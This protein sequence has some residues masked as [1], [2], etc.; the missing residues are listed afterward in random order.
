L[1]DWGLIAA[2]LAPLVPYTHFVPL[3]EVS[4]VV[5]ND[6]KADITSPLSTFFRKKVDYFDI[7]KNEIYH[8]SMTHNSGSTPYFVR[9]KHID[10]TK[11]P[12]LSF[13][14]ERVRNHPVVLANGEKLVVRPD[15]ELYPEYVLPPRMVLALAYALPSNFVPV[16]AVQARVAEAV[17]GLRKCGYSLAVLASLF[18]DLMEV[19][20]PPLREECA[21]IRSKVST[22]SSLGK[23]LSSS[24]VEDVLQKAVDCC[25][26]QGGTTPMSALMSALTSNNFH[27]TRNVLGSSSARSTEEVIRT[28]LLKH[29]RVYFGRDGDSIYLRGKFSFPPVCYVVNKIPSAAT[30]DRWVKA[31]P[32]SNLDLATMPVFDDAKAVV[33]TYKASN[34]KKADR[35]AKLLEYV[36]A[37]T[38]RMGEDLA[39]YIFYCILSD[40]IQMSNKDMNMLLDWPDQGVIAEFGPRITDFVRKYPDRFV[41]EETKHRGQGEYMISR[42][43]GSIEGTAEGVKTLED[44]RYYDE[45]FMAKEIL[46]LVEEHQVESGWCKELKITGQ[47]S[48]SGRKILQKYY[49][50][51]GNFIETRDFSS[52]RGGLEV[53]RTVGGSE[54]LVRFK[55]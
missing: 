23:E 5:P 29:H 17:P 18:P 45:A 21:R 12:I 32:A 51:L 49:G 47:L 1:G 55:M 39:D 8:R 28:F 9:R 27:A 46:A 43:T 19:V 54:V 30:V 20:V 48:A 41:I 2:K 35:I 3:D 26:D 53:R 22:F 13:C 38:P 16:E 15:A 50:G 14:E 52:M 6:I 31:A 11:Y 34:K 44:E 37:V 36:E 33:N 25:N 40:N 24:D 4:N 7:K 10:P 42:A